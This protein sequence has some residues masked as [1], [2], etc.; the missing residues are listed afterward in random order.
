MRTFYEEW[1]YIENSELLMNDSEEENLAP[2]GAKME[3]VKW[4][5]PV[6]NQSDFPFE[7][8]FAI[9]F[10]HHRTILSKVKDKK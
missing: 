6:P 5:L 3:I 8:F 10:S 7:A 1:S 4:N 9:G 2:A